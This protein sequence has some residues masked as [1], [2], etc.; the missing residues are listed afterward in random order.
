M[1][2]QRQRLYPDGALAANVLGLVG[3]DGAGLA[4][5]ESAYNTSL[6][7]KNGTLVVEQ[8]PQGRVI[9][10]AAHRE[11]DPVAGQ[12][13]QL[14]IDRNIQFAAEQA[15]GAQVK[16][17]GA[18]KGVAIVMSPQTGDIY[19]MASTPGFNPNNPAKANPADLQN[20]AVE[21]AFEPGSVN[22]L[23]TLSAAIDRG[24]VTPTT[25]VDLPASS[26]SSGIKG[27]GFL[28]HDA[29]NHP[30]QRATVAGVLAKSS[31][32]GTLLI[33]RLL[34]SRAA[35]EGELRSFG[36]GSLTGVGLPGESAGLLAKSSSW[37]QSQAANIPFGQSM[38]VTAL[39]VA[40]AYAT[41]ADGGVHV[42]PRIIEGT[43]DGHGTLSRSPAGPARRVVSTQTATTMSQLLEQVTTTNGTA[44]L[45]S[46]P[47]YRVAGKTGTAARVDPKTGKYAGYVASFVGFAP[48]D[49]PSLVVLVSL[50]NPTSS[51]FGG[52]VAA[53]TFA[54]I[55]SFAL[56]RLRVP[57]TGTPPVVYPLSVG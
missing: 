33:S 13:L 31:N 35:L 4:G 34:P 39:Q 37:S 52:S 12:G 5:L 44:P 1:L 21:W 7:G 24:I 45:A 20:P 11:K 2:P 29:E 53:P 57:P 9:P 40:A 25:E 10:A 48:A 27:N 23:I 30:A 17:S 26:P 51:I 28:I 6:A 32:L 41:I 14:T 46:I 56:A 19:A 49:K 15:L 18:I 50:D 8:D 55:M 36:L 3:R 42:T 38:S 16:A 47:G 43:L 22:K 54:K